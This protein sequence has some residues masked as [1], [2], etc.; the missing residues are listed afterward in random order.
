[1]LSLMI[2]LTPLDAV[3]EKAGWLAQKYRGR[4]A[5]ALGFSAIEMSD[6]HGVSYLVVPGVKVKRAYSRNDKSAPVSGGAID[7]IDDTRINFSRTTAQSIASSM[8]DMTPDQEKAYKNV[9][10]VKAVPTV[11]ERMDALK[12]NLGLKL[13]QGLVDQFA[14]I[15]QL[16]QNAYVQARMSKG[17]DGTLEAMLMYG[18]PLHA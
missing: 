16:D 4:V 9:A 2:C 10:G 6:E 5:Q 7:T 13:R 1:M 3:L 18:K 17:T 11:R 15:K 12:A 8:G 14:A